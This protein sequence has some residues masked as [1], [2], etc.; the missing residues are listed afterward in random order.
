LPSFIERR[1][2][3]AAVYNDAL[4]GTSYVPPFVAADCSHSYYIYALRHGKAQIIMKKLMDL[5]IPCGTYYPVPMHLQGV[6][7]DLG[8]KPGDLPISEALAKETFAI[9]IFPELY[10]EEQEQIIKALR[11]VEI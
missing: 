6:F 10:K 3:H 4:K 5:G 8:Y 9:P 7:A 11:E 1:Q 2:K